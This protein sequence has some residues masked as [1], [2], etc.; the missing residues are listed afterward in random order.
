[1]PLDEPTESAKPS[2]ANPRDA[3]AAD[4]GRADPDGKPA[5]PEA[6]AAVFKQLAEAVEYLAYLLATQVDRA[7]L[8]IR[9]LLILVALGTLAAVAGL[10]FV[11]CTVWLLLAGIAGGVGVL[12][13]DRPW[14]GGIVTATVILIVG[15]SVGWIFYRRIR[16]SGLKSARRRYQERQAEQKSRFGRE[17]RQTADSPSRD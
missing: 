12:L 11:A 2:D 10:A 16:T 14:L 3:S 4:A 17:V 1:M 9:N 8:K 6:L 13:G 7:K 5:G 15:G